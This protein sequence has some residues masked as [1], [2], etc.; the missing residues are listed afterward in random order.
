MQ[1]WI[2]TAPFGLE[3]VVADEL[4][5]AVPHLGGQRAGA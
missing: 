3:G 2:A 5:A 4:R 1:Q